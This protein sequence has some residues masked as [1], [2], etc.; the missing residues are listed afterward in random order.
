MFYDGFKIYCKIRNLRYLRFVVFSYSI[1]VIR[2]SPC[3]SPALSPSPT[4]QVYIPTTVQS[5]PHWSRCLT[6]YIPPH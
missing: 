4:P 5:P 3:H 2:L 6:Q 1:S